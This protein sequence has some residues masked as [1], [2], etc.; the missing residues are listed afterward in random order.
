MLDDIVSEELRLK[1]LNLLRVLHEQ[2]IEEV[3]MGGLMRILGIQ[4]E[5]AAE[6]DDKALALDADLAKYMSDTGSLRDTTQTLH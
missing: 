3:H 2:G 1:I 4:N 5:T 6:F